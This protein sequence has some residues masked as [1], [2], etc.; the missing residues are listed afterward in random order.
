MDLFRASSGVLV[1][2]PRNRSD[3]NNTGGRG[4]GSL[5]PVALALTAGECVSFTPLSQHDLVE[6]AGY[7][8]HGR[9]MPR[10]S[11]GATCREEE[12]TGT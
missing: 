12:K 8:L 1:P 3:G 7:G 10:H 9:A 11:P 6:R 5:G 2:R 4:G